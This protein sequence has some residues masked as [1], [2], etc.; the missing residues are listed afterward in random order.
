[1]SFWC[2]QFPPKNERKQVSLVVKLNSFVRFLEETSA[3][4]NHWDFVRPLAIN[5]FLLVKAKF[6]KME[7]AAFTTNGRCSLFHLFKNSLR[8]TKSLRLTMSRHTNPRRVLQIIRNSPIFFPQCVTYCPSVQLLYQYYIG[9]L[10][11]ILDLC[12]DELLIYKIF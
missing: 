2:L 1:M 12:Q 11:P 4:K 7:Y 6:Q 3:W 9:M 8:P 5:E 10:H